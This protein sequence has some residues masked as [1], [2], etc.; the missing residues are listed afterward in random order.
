MTVLLASEVFPPQTGGSGRWLY[1][2]YRR[3]PRGSVVVAAGEY[4]GMQEFDSGEEL[5]IE[6]MRLTF[7]T[8]GLASVRGL[9]SYWRAY[10]RLAALVKEHGVLELHCGTCLPEGWLAWML[11]R[12]R[13]IEYVCY[14]H[15]EE[16]AI[17]RTSRQLTWMARRVFR[18]ARLV[19][20]NSQNT[21]RLLRERWPVDE[22]RLAVLNPGVDAQRFVP[23]EHDER[24]R[25]SLGW[26]GRRVVL[27]VGRL[28]IRK[29]HDMLI[30]AL[31]AIARRVPNV[32]YAIVGDGGERQRLEKLVEELGVRELVR[33]HGELAD[34]RLIECYQQCD[35]FVLANREVNG[36]FEG[37]GMVLVEAQA[38]GKPVIA[39]ASGGTHETMRVPETG[40]IVPCE[41]P[42]KL[43][44]AVGDLLAN[45]SRR[46]AMGQAARKWA[47]EQFDWTSLAQQASRIL[48]LEEEGANVQKNQHESD[49]AVLQSH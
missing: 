24:V 37:F 3:M 38:C 10:R 18:G 46:K 40:L 36:D 27:T 32:L 21:A 12:V 44:E 39:G 49:S 7:P 13:G 43:T 19:V 8:W 31:P 16:L 25:Q 9:S 29:G 47:L 11:R 20:A 41:S 17:A 5:A 23:A 14:V 6:R 2:V 34:E 35:L 45:E 15:G 1:E 22:T 33:F 28:Q 42:E 4:A 30:R 48:G 26:S